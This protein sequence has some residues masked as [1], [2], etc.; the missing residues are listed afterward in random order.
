MKV[1]LS[2]LLLLGVCAFFWVTLGKGESVVTPATEIT[3]VYQETY[4]REAQRWQYDESGLRNIT[5]TI[6]SGYRESGSPVTFMEGLLVTGTDRDSRRWKMT[7]AAGKLHPNSR[8]LILTQGVKVTE[9]DV[10]ATLT[11]PRLRLLLNEER[12]VSAARVRL[13]TPTSNT[14]ARGLEIDLTHGTAK[15]LNNVKTR[16][17]DR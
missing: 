7:A 1:T 11:T 15:L 3:E 9:L 4:L 8:E 6:D 17:V 10:D 14:T 16:Y 12:A 13:A 2:S 5:V